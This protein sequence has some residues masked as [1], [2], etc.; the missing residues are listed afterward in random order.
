MQLD[1]IDF[2]GAGFSQKVLIDVFERE[3]DFNRCFCLVGL[4]WFYQDGT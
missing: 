2:E 3:M 1:E 4:V